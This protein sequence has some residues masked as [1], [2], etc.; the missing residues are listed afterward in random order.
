MNEPPDEPP[1]PM[2]MLWAQRAAWGIAR[3]LVCWPQTAGV[4][5]WTAALLRFATTGETITIRRLAP[6]ERNEGEERT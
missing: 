5:W 2:S 3:E 4:I 1:R 6:V